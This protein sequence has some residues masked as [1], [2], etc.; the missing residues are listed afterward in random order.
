MNM[1]LSSSNLSLELGQIQTSRHFYHHP[2]Y[3]SNAS[4]IHKRNEKRD[5]Q[6]ILHNYGV[7]ANLYCGL[8]TFNFSQ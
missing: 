7:V 2:L 8:P 5:A 3:I 1:C 4:D 6:I